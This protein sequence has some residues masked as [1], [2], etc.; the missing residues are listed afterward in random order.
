MGT[1]TS[2]IIAFKLIVF[3]FPGGCHHAISSNSSHLTLIKSEPTYTQEDQTPLPWDL[4]PFINLLRF[5]K[6][7][8]I[9]RHRILQLLIEDHIVPRSLLD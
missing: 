5:V 8:V 6:T 1:L 3:P 4:Q 2:F 7:P 9:V